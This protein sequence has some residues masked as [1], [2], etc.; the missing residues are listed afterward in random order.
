MRE[1]K[2][3]NCKKCGVYFYV[4]EHHILPRSIFGNQGNTVE[5]CP[6]CHTHF[7][8]YSKK[9]TLDP[10][11]EQEALKIWTTWLKKIPLIVSLLLV[12]LFLWSR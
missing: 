12:G 11:D 4:H 9:H 6:N 5:L 1:A 8:E 2:K 10:K 7:H 3:G